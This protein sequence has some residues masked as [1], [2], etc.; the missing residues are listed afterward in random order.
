MDR[1][2]HT[3]SGEACP[4]KLG[5]NTNVWAAAQFGQATRVA[6]LLARDAP[7]YANK[8]D[9]YGHTPLHYAAQH[10][11]TEVV[12][13]LLAHGAKVDAR[14]CGC[15]PLARAALRTADTSRCANCSWRRAQ[16]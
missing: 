8:E 12:Q 10:G 13:L 2:D 4:C 3:H 16:P 7:T 5:L 9:E 14:A 11:R 6:E 1:Y 15:T